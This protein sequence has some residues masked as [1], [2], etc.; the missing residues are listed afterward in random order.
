MVSHIALDHE[1]ATAQIVTYHISNHAVDDYLTTVMVLA[2]PS[3]PLANTSMVGPFMNTP[4]S[5]PGVPFMV[6]LTFCCFA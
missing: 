3:C 4:M 6:F 5:L 2:M 1:L